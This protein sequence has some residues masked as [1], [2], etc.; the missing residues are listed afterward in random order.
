MRALSVVIENG[1]NFDD[2]IMGTDRVR[3]HRRELRGIALLD[4]DG[5]LAE[6][7]ASCAAED[8]EPFV[9]GV[10]RQRVG[11]AGVFVGDAHLR[12]GH[13][14]QGTFAGE[15]PGGEAG[16][17][18]RLRPDHHI[19][20]V[21]GLDQVIDRGVECARDRDELI[22]CD[23]ATAGFDATQVRRTDVAAGCQRIECPSTCESQTSDALPDDLVQ[24]DVF[25]LHGQNDMP[26]MH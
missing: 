21:I 23:S 25:L 20:V 16:G 26:N 12:D 13:S 17:V 1:E 8:R 11:G 6:L 5:A 9:P 7:E 19:L 2:T 22:Q 18:V 14:V 4:E 10:D 3:R 15:Q 24:I